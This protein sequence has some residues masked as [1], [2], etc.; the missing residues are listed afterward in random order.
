[1]VEETVELARDV[2]ERVLLERLAELNARPD[3]DGILVQLPLPK[4]LSAETVVGAIDPGKDVDGLHPLNQGALFGGRQGLRPCTP[5]ACMDLL[6]TTGVVPRGKRAV[7]V[8]RSVLV[9]RPVAMLLLESDATVVICHSRTP[10]LPVHVASADILV[11]A[12]G[13]PG[14]VRGDWIK[15]GSVVI[16]VGI[17][18]VDGRLVG[19]VEFAGAAERAG[20]ITP[21][22]GGVGPMTVAMLLRNTYAAYLARDRGC[23]A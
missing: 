22:P 15:P 12:V 21:V 16:D 13:V 7:V 23:Q 20:H 8:G 11:V 1:M 3:I 5:L 10:D 4:H 19:D 14:L 6:A 18:R 9:G 17:N 2:S